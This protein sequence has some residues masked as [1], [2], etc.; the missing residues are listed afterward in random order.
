M[1]KLI[2]I[3]VILVAGFFGSS[4]YIEGL[5]SKAH[6]E[7]K[8]IA[9]DPKMWQELLIKQA[10]NNRA[11]REQMAGLL[12]YSSELFLE[13]EDY[14]KGFLSS[15]AKFSL[16]SKSQFHDKPTK[17]LEGNITYYNLPL[18]KRFKAVLKKEG[19]EKEN[20]KLANAI[21]DENLLVFEGFKTFFDWEVRMT[22]ADILLEEKREGSYSTREQH[23]EVKPT[24]LTLLLDGKNPML[25][26]SANADIPYINITENKKWE[27]GENSN[28]KFLIEKLQITQ[29]NAEPTPIFDNNFIEGDAKMFLKKLEF[30]NND[31]Y[32]QTNSYFKFQ[33]IKSSAKTLIKDNKMSIDTKSSAELLNFK[34]TEKE[35]DIELKAPNLVFNIK[36]L[37][38]EALNKVLNYQDFGALETMLNQTINAN[39]EFSTKINKKDLDI[40]ASM[41]AQKEN[42]KVNATILSEGK[43]SELAVLP[44][45]IKSDLESLDSMAKVDGKE[46][47]LEVILDYNPKNDLFPDVKINGKSLS[48]YQG[49]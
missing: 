4:F 21:K 29:N 45:Y 43:F 44:S 39:L 46:Y 22:S 11:L 41:Q 31:E 20:Q 14:Q 48:E 34:D 6:E 30:N 36:D 3:I 7:F 16:M 10:E 18:S 15:N 1:K 47:K 8:K 32:Y 26:K 19:I 23:I 49:Y 27:N 28:N 2:A 35:V 24:S 12:Y 42:L 37:D 25:L 9:S 5:N 13:F 17:L 33:D 38:V 40:K